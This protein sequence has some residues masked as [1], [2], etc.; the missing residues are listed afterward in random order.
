MWI[1]T[2]LSVLGELSAYGLLWTHL[3]Y[4][5]LTHASKEGF[6]LK[7]LFNSMLLRTSHTCV[8]KMCMI[9]CSQRPLLQ[10]H[11]QE[12]NVCSR[13][14]LQMSHTHCPQDQMM[15]RGLGGRAGC[16]VGLWAERLWLEVR[17]WT[18]PPMVRAWQPAVLWLLSGVA[19]K[20]DSMLVNTV[21][22]LVS[23]ELHKI[24]VSWGLEGTSGDPQP[25]PAKA[26]SWEWLH[27]KASGQVLNISREKK[28]FLIFR[29][30]KAF[31]KL[32]SSLL[33][34]ITERCPWMFFLSVPWDVA[35]AASTSPSPAAALPP[36]G[37][38]H[39]LAHYSASSRLEE[40]F[41]TR[42]PSV[43]PQLLTV[44]Y[45][46]FANSN[47]GP[48]GQYPLGSACWLRSN[49]SFKYIYCHFF[50]MGLV[51]LFM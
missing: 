10:F 12:D 49:F 26:R 27:R 16:C 15:R 23:K 43:S 34:C 46:S 32:F 38:V 40:K 2:L 24:T 4:K 39:L 13:R 45:F 11:F 25:S 41:F 17:E 37:R 6:R 44:D 21:N 8:C 5:N 50:Y 30:A 51:N 36:S 48:G 33:F 18:H 42:L 35:S 3:S 14:G 22:C 7:L 1:L 31:K 47:M 9:S 19:F 29:N 20:P 28:F